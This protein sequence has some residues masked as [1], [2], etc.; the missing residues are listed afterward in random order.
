MTEKEGRPNKASQCVLVAGANRGF[1]PALTEGFQLLVASGLGA[2]RED[3][4]GS[5]SEKEA[6]CK[7]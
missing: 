5:V 7:A 1:T 3:R 4:L 2:T 6:G